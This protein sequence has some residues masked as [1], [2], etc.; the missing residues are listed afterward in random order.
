MKYK[1][2]IACGH[3]DT[4]RAAE[5]ILQE[6]GNAFDAA[7]AAYFAACVT[8]TVLASL[9]GGGFFLTHCADGKNVLYDFFSQ[10]PINRRKIDEVDFFPFNADFGTVEQEF[11]IG[12]GAAAT[13]GAVRGIF[14]VYRELCTMPMT[15]LVEPAFLLAKDG[16][17]ID[18]FQVSFFQVM[19]TIFN[20]TDESIDI[21]GSRRSKGEPIQE[22]E[23]FKQPDLAN[24]LDA[25]AREGDK[26]FY[27]G[28]IAHQ[29]EKI[30]KERG[31]CLNSEDLA[32]YQT[33]KRPPF[34]IKYKGV[35][36]LINSPPAIGGILIGFALKLLEN[37][38][39]QDIGLGT[40][41]HINLIANVLAS[42]NS[43][44]IKIC[45][46]EPKKL[47][48]E[49][50]F[51]PDYME[52]YKKKIYGGK[53]STRG[54]SHISILD[55]KGNM[56][57]LTI[58]NGEGCGHIIPKTGIMLNNFLGEEDLNPIGYYR[59]PSN[60]RL[61]STMA[62]TLMMRPDGSNYALG[63]GGCSRIRSAVLQ[64]LINLIDFN[65]SVPDAVEMPRIHIDND[66]L[67]I[68]EGYKPEEIEKIKSDFPNVKLWNKTNL[69]F[70]GVHSAMISP[71]NVDGKGDS[72][73][74]GFFKVVE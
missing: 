22:G 39:I 35:K 73:R 30:C 70:G 6:G 37:Y 17:T 31:G 1:G 47:K 10:T 59:W 33:A 74:G 25:L 68:E 18:A 11:Y 67:N 71:R 29:I 62:P 34:Q 55:N 72:R 13:P 53:L 57:S 8:E 21:F 14:T 12:L 63:T 49:N 61:I 23:F 58:S 40:A 32:L 66:T 36:I 69:Y 48:T 38:K 56:A 46:E 42:T 43:T 50:I 16:F 4:A 52:I 65:M 26:L 24:T 20:L 9:G 7:I 60:Q 44:K 54:T 2:V 28:E 15:R 5:I 41:E 45:A 3:K 19:K 51:D 64:V 27:E